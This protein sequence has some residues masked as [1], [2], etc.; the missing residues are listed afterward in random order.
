MLDEIRLK[1][2]P[3]EV[4]HRRNKAEFHN[5]GLNKEIKKPPCKSEFAIRR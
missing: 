5:L 1:S 4:K 3:E 2:N